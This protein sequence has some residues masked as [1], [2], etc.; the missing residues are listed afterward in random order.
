MDN[1]NQSMPNEKQLKLPKLRK[2]ISFAFSDYDLE[3]KPQ[4]VIHDSGRNKFFIIGLVE[5]EIIKRWSLGQA[6][7]LVEAVNK[8]TTLNIEL[9]DVENFAKFLQNNYLIQQTGYQI[10]NRAKEQNIFK[11]D[12]WWHWLI[13]YY[14]FFKVPLLHPDHF[15][16][17]TQFIGKW[18]FSRK[19]GY[20]MIVL[21]I[22]A[23]YQ[24]SMRWDEFTH[25]FPT[26][27][28]WQGFFYYFIAYSVCKLLH[29]LG[30]AYQCKEYGVPV[31]ALG[32]AFLVFWPVLYTDTTL[33]WSL[34]SNQRMRIALAGILVETYITIIAALIWSNVHNQ[35][36]QTICYVTI[37][38]NWI[39][40][41]LINVSPFMRF[42]GYYVLADYLKIPN[43]QPRAFALARWQIRH[44]LFH[45]PDPPPEQFTPRMH[46][47]LV[48]YSFVTWLYRLF[49][50][51]GIALLV[52]HFF[53]KVVGIILF[54]IELYYFILGPVVR[55]IQTW[56]YF[57]EKFS[58]NLRTKI[59]TFLMIFLCL[60]FFLPINETVKLPGTLSYL[61]E[62][63]IAPDDGII[64]NT[65]P[66]IGTK[67]KA[68]QPIVKINS[69]DLNHQLEQTQ[70][71]Y[72][73]WVEELRRASINTTFSNQKNILLSHI[74][75][76]QAKY[77][78]LI[79]E[80]NKL[81]LTV[82]FNGV[83]VDVEPDLL[84]GTA[85]PKGAWIGDII[86][87]DQVE[88][89]AFVSQVDVNN[90]HPGLTGH[91]YPADI[92]EPIVPVTV[93]TIEIVNSSKL[94]CS[95]STELKQNK[96]ENVVVETPCYHISELGG[97]IAAFLTEEAEYV[98]VD[99]M[100]RVVLTVQKKTTISHIQRGTVILK[101]EPVSYADR[102]FYNF[103]TLFI[104]Q[105]GF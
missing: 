60:I 35:I 20:L 65:V 75:E 84:P 38:I 19:M 61:H 1:P 10:Y 78:K 37:T 15:L 104:K 103:K 17:K 94:I 4:W 16:T 59:T 47:L 91:F 96:K 62:F 28:T 43:L 3:G 2:G 11:N 42:D 88:V 53:I 48:A 36:I 83:I 18:L 54:S 34:K 31:P 100:F 55:E 98:P 50:Y 29:E 49:I 70:L 13:N 63:L 99:S 5:Y 26:I 25:T 105:S 12:S 87:P 80:H 95:Y 64:E 77:S 52:Y 40:S 74:H 57:K 23:L 22:I 66:P 76:E 101:T 92:S 9:S 39:A 27:F 72:N 6:D 90:L 21:A 32:I 24:L 89:E 41:L 69:P 68:N 81:T 33:S 85:V 44:W 51:F 46:R 97:D 86:S 14:L 79:N 102:V 71:E 7:L 67:I 8:E 56:I 30:H 73:K 58:F 82:P 93:R 45:W